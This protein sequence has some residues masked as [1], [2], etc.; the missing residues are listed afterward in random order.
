MARGLIEGK[1]AR[2]Y[3]AQ[4]KHSKVTKIFD[5]FI[6]NNIKPNKKLKVCDF[7]CGSGITIELLKGKVAEITGVDASKEMIKICREKFG[8]NPKIKLRLSSVTKTGLNSNYFDYVIIRMS[9]HHIQDKEK[10]INEAYR[11]LKPKGKAI[12]IDKFCFNWFKLYIQGLWKLI[13]RFDAFLF[14]HFIKSEEYNEQLLSKRF[15]IV[16]KEAPAK[17]KR[18]STQAFMFVLVKKE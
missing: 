9:L 12:V 6:L 13:F 5:N 3:D 11:V 1:Q 7:C 16:K 18:F 2:K 17:I 4:I 14:N 15:K 8:R 10:A